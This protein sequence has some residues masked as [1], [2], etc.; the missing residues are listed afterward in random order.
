M[1]DPTP[2]LQATLQA[3]PPAPFPATLPAT[4]PATAPIAPASPHSALVS[5][6]FSAISPAALLADMDFSPASLKDL[7]S[8][9][10]SSRR[11]ETLLLCWSRQACE[12]ESLPPVSELQ[13]AAQVLTRVVSVR[14]TIL[15]LAPAEKPAPT[16]KSWSPDSFA[17]ASS[18][19][20]FGNI[21]IPGEMTM[22][23][24]Q[25]DLKAAGITERP[26]FMDSSP[27]TG[28]PAKPSSPAPSAQDKAC[29]PLS[30]K[31]PSPS[32]ELDFS[33][34]D[35]EE[36]PSGGFDDELDQWAANRDARR[37]AEADP[38]PLAPSPNSLASLSSSSTPST[39]STPRSTPRSTSVS[40]VHAC[41][42][43]S[44]L[45]ASSLDCTSRLMDKLAPTFSTPS[46]FPDPAAPAAPEPPSPPTPS[47]KAPPRFAAPMIVDDAQPPTRP[48]RGAPYYR[49]TGYD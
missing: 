13:S 30:G 20:S 31:L 45:S 36:N 3:A 26:R 47:R 6:P 46:A 39:S 44:N 22:A 12:A 2:T 21:H 9:I 8:V 14:K 27:R 40:A 28:P 11:I 23:E 19:Q 41:P 37:A 35:E 18:Y 42:T 7:S 38:Q 49:L 34:L 10:E 24:L 17:P 48:I 15:A 29:A 43:L 25:A 33:Y 16:P 32:H 4:L 1:T 5:P